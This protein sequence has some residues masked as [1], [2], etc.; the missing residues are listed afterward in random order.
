MHSSARGCLTGG[1]GAT[2]NLVGS[3]YKT[4]YAIHTTGGVQHAFNQHWLMSA[5]LRSRARQSRLP[6]LP[7]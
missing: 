5:D 4:P 2:G 3:P 7:L 6:R 1:S